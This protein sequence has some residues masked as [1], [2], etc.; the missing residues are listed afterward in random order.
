[1]NTNID[2][3]ASAFENRSEVLLNDAYRLRRQTTRYCPAPPRCY[4][5]RL[6]SSTRWAACQRPFTSLQGAKVKTYAL[7][8]KVGRV[9]KR[10]NRVLIGRY[11]RLPYGVWGVSVDGRVSP[12]HKVAIPRPNGATHIHTIAEIY[13]KRGSIRLCSVVPVTSARIKE[14]FHD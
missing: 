7:L 11:E 1:M 13:Y 14:V 6:A 3:L 8:R 2:S 10:G 12:G 4:A 5:P 9:D